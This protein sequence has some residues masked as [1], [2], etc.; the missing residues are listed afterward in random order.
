[1]TLLKIEPKTSQFEGRLFTRYSDSQTGHGHLLSAYAQKAQVH[2][3]VVWPIYFLMFYLA[4][5]Q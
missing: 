4:T 3:H 1:M 2:M 5:V